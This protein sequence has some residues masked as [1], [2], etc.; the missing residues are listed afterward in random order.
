MFRLLARLRAFQDAELNGLT[1][2]LHDVDRRLDMAKA[3]VLCCADFVNAMRAI[4]QMQGGCV[5]KAK[6]RKGDNGYV[7]QQRGW[8]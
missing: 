6:G 1:P 2:R 8:L 7:N 3:E 5:E 4:V